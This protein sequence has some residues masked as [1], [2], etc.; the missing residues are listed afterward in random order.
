M[1]EEHESGIERLAGD[2]LQCCV[3]GRNNQ[4][5]R[6]VRDTF[7]CHTSVGGCAVM[8]TSR[9]LLQAFPRQALDKCRSSLGGAG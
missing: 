2:I 5:Q 4:G 6:E 9:E 7:H 8:D 3:L 1:V